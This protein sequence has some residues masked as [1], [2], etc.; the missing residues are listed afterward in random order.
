MA[1]SQ[2]G[3][4]VAGMNYTLRCEVSRRISGLTNTPTALWEHNDG[5]EIVSGGSMLELQFTN[6]RTSQNGPYVCRGRLM[7][8]ALDIPQ[9]DTE[10]TVVSVQSEYIFGSDQQ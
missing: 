10:S 8:P 9:E 5:E 3:S 1:V 2:L 6:L 4:P 7:S